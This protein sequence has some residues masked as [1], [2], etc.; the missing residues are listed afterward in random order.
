MDKP[1]RVVLLGT[2]GIEK[3]QIAENLSNWT[4]EKLGHSFRIIDFEK[5]YLTDSKKG[6]RSLSNFLAKD[7]TDQCVT[8]H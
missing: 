8:L 1:I 5:D 7:V 3:R 4:K 6:R 2:T